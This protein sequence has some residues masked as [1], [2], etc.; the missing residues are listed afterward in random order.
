MKAETR[1]RPKSKFARFPTFVSRTRYRGVAGIAERKA[2][3]KDSSLLDAYRYDSMVG[4]P[5]WAAGDPLVAHP[6]P[7]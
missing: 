4:R 1:L 6:A 3:Q 2:E 7:D 5:P